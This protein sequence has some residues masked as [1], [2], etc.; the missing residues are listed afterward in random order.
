M[1]A[2]TAHKKDPPQERA[3]NRYRAG[4]SG[5]AGMKGRR[6]ASLLGLASLGIMAGLGD[7]RII[8]EVKAASGTPP[9]TEREIGHALQTAHRDTAP[10]TDRPQSATEW[11]PPPPK[12]PPLGTGAKGFVGRMIG[13]GR[14]A[15]LASLAL[16]SPVPVP[17]GPEDQARAFLSSL[18]GYGDRLFMGAST[19][20][21][22]IGAT[23]RT[24]AEWRDAFKT[25]APPPFVIAN[26]LT[27]SE[28]KTKEGKPSF[29]CGACIAA[30]RYALVEF[31]DM[32]VEDQAAFWAGVIAL[33]TLPLRSLTHSGG[34]SIHGLVEIG[35]KDQGEWTR[36]IDTL[37]FAVA[38][39]D[40]PQGHRADRA[41]KNPDRL[42]RT[43]GAYRTDKS[44]VQSLLWLGG[45]MLENVGGFEK[46]GSPQKTSVG[47]P[48]LR[49]PA[50]H[51]HTR[52]EPSE[53]TGGPQ[54]NEGNAVKGRC[55]DCWNWTPDGIRHGCAAAV[56]SRSS[57]AWRGPCP[58]FTAV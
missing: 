55:F 20:A 44:R 38:N 4:L 12:P 39:P 43:P 18:Y 26:P 16:S 51:A 33:G 25:V 24:A 45:G 23:I 35:A 3:L 31:D 41:C 5:L 13:R 42:T 32:P 40:A 57:P 8:A 37:L 30:F 19:D 28:G 6:N 10:L 54:G 34:K 15:S 29:R 11:I 2:M 17:S 21:G 47:A 58:N 36:A 56:P 46:H 53:A 1:S 49:P 50:T 48:P 52:P 9:L 14:G 7:V 22:V 27:G